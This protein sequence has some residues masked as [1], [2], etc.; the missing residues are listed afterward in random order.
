MPDF[1]KDWD[2]E[3]YL[4]LMLAD[5]R[6]AIR[7]IATFAI[8]KR[9]KFESYDQMSFFIGRNMRPAK[10]LACFPIEKIVST[11]EHLLKT[12]DYKVTLE[13]VEKF[14]LEDIPGKTAPKERIL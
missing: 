14:I 10:R 9:Y 3:K 1:K 12:A 11:L 7:I 6:P 8:L 2:T 13:T 5:K 4:D